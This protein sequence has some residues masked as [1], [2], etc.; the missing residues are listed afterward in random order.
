MVSPIFVGREASL[1]AIQEAQAGNRPVIGLVQKDAELEDPKPPDFLT[2]WDR[3][4]GGTPALDAGWVI[5][6]PG[7]GTSTA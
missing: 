7:A 1:L 5:E 6:R 3:D 4:G 2:R